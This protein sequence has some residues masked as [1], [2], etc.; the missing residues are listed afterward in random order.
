MSKFRFRHTLLSCGRVR[1]TQGTEIEN[2]GLH[3][4]FYQISIQNLSYQEWLRGRGFMW[5][6]V[7]VSITT[8]KLR[9]DIKIIV[10]N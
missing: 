2:E 7:S 8:F 5:G 6:F 3:G 10:H 9:Y 1:K 4:T